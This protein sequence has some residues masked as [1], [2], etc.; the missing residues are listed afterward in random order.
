MRKFDLIADLK[1]KTADCLITAEHFKTLTAID[2][3]Q[4]PSPDSWSI[5]ACLEHLNLYGDFYLI[6]L[7]DKILKAKAQR[8]DADFKSGWFGERTVQS[9]LPKNEQVAKMKTFHSKDP[10]YTDLNITIIDRFIKQQGQLMG[11]LNMAE[12][13][14]LSSTTTRITLPI[15]R[16]K[17]GTTLRFVV[18]HNVRHIWQAKNVMESINK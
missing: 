1:A 7:E 4:R 6:E 16:F 11:L 14:D 15:I 8:S 2:L 9:M 12:Q 17:L 18:Y 5:L 10:G 3:N 13:I